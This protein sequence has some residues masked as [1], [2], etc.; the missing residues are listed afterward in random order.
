MGYSLPDIILDEYRKKRDTN[1][2]S[3]KNIMCIFQMIVKIKSTQIEY[4]N[5]YA[6]F[7]G[8][9]YISERQLEFYKRLQNR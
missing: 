1:G 9:E 3:L 7:L 5:T 2:N 6:N 8:V 4:I